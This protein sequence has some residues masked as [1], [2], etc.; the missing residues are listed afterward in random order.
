MSAEPTVPPAAAGPSGWPNLSLVIPTW[1]GRRLL[2]ANL[3]SVQAALEQYRADTG[4]EGEVVVVDDGSRDDTPEFLAGLGPDRIRAIRRETNGGFSAACNTGFRAAIHPVVV[5]LNND[6][7]PERGFLRPLAQHFTVPDVFG[8]TCRALLPGTR[9]PGTGGKLAHFRKGFWSMQFNYE[10]PRGDS[11]GSWPSITAIGGFAALDRR[12]VLAMGG[13][14]E[15]YNP[16]YWEDIDLSYRAWAR[17]W[18]VLYEPRSVVFHPP[19]STIGT[20]FRRRQTDTIAARN[21]LLFH[22]INLRDPWMLARH[23]GMVGLLLLSQWAGRRR[24]FYAAFGQALRGLPE[25]R[26]LRR[27]EAGHRVRSDREIVRIFRDLESRGGIRI[28]R[29][30]ADAVALAEAEEA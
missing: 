14:L 4:A 21:R 22:W 27:E 13:F 10:P 26:R 25:A 24:E 23:A 28:L 12:K 6:V 18:R 15:L 8:V 9:V 2:A 19:S 7:Q 17:G 5:L 3:P 29:R 11:S 30:H 1:N 20:A 16:F